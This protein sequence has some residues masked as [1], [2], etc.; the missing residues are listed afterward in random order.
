L[1]HALIVSAAGCAAMATPTRQ[2]T[3]TREVDSRA[4][5]KKGAGRFSGDWEGVD[6]GGSDDVEG[7]CE[8]RMSLVD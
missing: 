8:R 5:R 2:R 3:T 1:A 4:R 6:G 7:R